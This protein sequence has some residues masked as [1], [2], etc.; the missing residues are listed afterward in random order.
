MHSNPRSFLMLVA[1]AALLSWLTVQPAFA[2]G[3][4][5]IA[6]PGTGSFSISYV[7]QNA[8]EFFRQTTKVQGPLAP[9]GN[10]AQNTLWFSVNY[11]VSDSVAIDIQ[12]AWARSFSV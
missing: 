9:D 10:L 5:W 6:E 4:P 12:S 8:S 7:N 11:A 3:S 1:G 2:Q